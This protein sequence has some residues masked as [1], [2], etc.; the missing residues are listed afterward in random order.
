MMLVKPLTNAEVKNAKPQLKDYSLHD[1][2][3]LLLYVTKSGGKSWRFRYAHPITGKRQT[4][5][6]GRYP[7]FSLAEAREAREEARRKV[8][9]GIDPNEVKKE[10]L[11]DRRKKHAQQF[12]VIADNWLKIK[13]TEGIRSNTIRG[14][15]GALKTLNSVL[16]DEPVHKM[17]A[18]STIQAMREF[19]DRPASVEKMIV[20]LNSVMD[21]AVNTGVIDHNCLLKIGKAF[22]A[23]RSVPM[24]VMDKGRLPVFLS[25]WLGLSM[26]E[27]IRLCV[28]FQ[29]LT[30]VRPSEARLAVWDEIDLDSAVWKIPAERMKGKRPHAVPLST[31]AIAVL[32]NAEKWRRGAFIF[33]SGK[34]G[35]KP[36]GKCTGQIA[37]HKTSL[38]G[39]VVTHGLRSLASTVLNEE[40]FNPDVIE[41]ALAHRSRNA[42]RN[43]Y[44]RTDYFEQ[45]RMLMQWWGDYIDSAE[46]GE[47]LQTKGDKGLRLIG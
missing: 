38:S 13:I 14:Y 35:D 1:G 44:N 3:G 9:R 23:K 10:E 29:L 17:N 22:P 45:R 15:E 47:L 6:I 32:R 11:S 43:I 46:R 27:P 33:P 4:F 37:I 30:M 25:E 21:Y 24:P 5:T 34:K 8:A 42:I 40:G 12:S 39:E 2:F 19:A 28:Y 18:A 26:W 31:Q 7:E 36:I 16:G 41:A 20:V